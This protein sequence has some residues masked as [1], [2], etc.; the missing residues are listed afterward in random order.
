MGNLYTISRIFGAID[1]GEFNNLLDV[2]VL[3]AIGHFLED[4]ISP[5]YYP[6][7]ILNH[8]Q[9]DTSLDSIKESMQ[10]LVKEGKV[11]RRYFRYRR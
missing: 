8:L 10:R 11:P 3:E 6:I 5:P 9:M 4:Y 2:T 7:D 1:R